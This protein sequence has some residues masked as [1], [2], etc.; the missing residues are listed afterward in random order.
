MKPQKP[1][2][3]FPLFPHSNG[4]WAKKI[5]GKLCYFGLWDD[6]QAA[7]ACYFASCG[8]TGE[9][10]DD[11][12]IRSKV[13]RGDRPAKP[14][15]DFPLYAHN[16]GRWAKRIRR[17]VHYFGPWCDPD[18]ALA[19]YLDQKDDLLAGR[20]P[21]SG[22]GL[23]VRELVNRFLT[24]K[25]RRVESGE[26]AQVTWQ[27]YDET[28][29]RVVK[30]FGLTRQVASLR[31][32]DF[33]QLRCDFAKTHGPVR[34]SKDVTC[35]HVLFKFA[36]DQ[37]LIDKPVK[38][39]E[40]FRKP[41]KAVLRKARQLRV[42]ERGPRSFDAPELRKIISAAGT[43]LR[44]MIYLGVN[45]GFSNNDCA[46]LPTN[47]VDLDSGWIEYA[48]P[49]TGIQRR[50]P[51]WPET[52]SALRAALDARPI[53]EDEK[54]ANRVFITKYRNSWEPKSKKDSPISNEMTKLLK[55]LG[56]H[57][58]GVS[59][60]ALRHVFQTIGERTRDKDAVRTIMGHA[61]HSNDMS[62]VYNEEAVS[63][64]RLRAVTD[65]IRKW[66]LSKTQLRRA[67]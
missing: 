56:L 24:A 54:F 12:A 20:K 39:G 52:V 17:K 55:S 60:G 67:G 40:G 41:S 21:Q 22:D 15:K 59:F 48:R 9:Q 29:K 36:Y 33:E 46:T 47:V 44:A 61:E 16:S 62:V 23:T 26:L 51:L 53:P 63:D 43:Q 10:A 66:L 3:E 42:Q 14:H 64:A 6:P 8:E 38:F 25:L 4:Q 5:G 34:L 45:C 27:D 2:P 1:Y 57:R 50:C 32:S 7:L 18:A 31:P 30:V 28:C 11:T 37:D 65:F 49:K 35:V 19:K 58:K 13:T